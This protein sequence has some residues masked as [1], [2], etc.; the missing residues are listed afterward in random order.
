MLVTCAGVAEL[1]D[2][3]DLKS[4]GINFP[5]RFDSG[6]RHHSYIAGWSSSVARR[7][8]NPK[9]G[10][11]NPSPATTFFIIR[12]ISAAGS[13][14]HWQCWGQGFESPM[15]HHV[16]VRG[17]FTKSLQAV[18]SFL[19]RDRSFFPQSALR[20]RFVGALICGI[21]Q[22]IFVGADNIRPALHLG[23]AVSEAD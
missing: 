15:L 18:T 10:G 4:R 8:H 23:R 3:R 20:W 16:A 7:A 17:V 12:G 14:Q 11:S 2:A 9:V 5:Y 6:L 1:A 22:K 13:A 21:L 19:S